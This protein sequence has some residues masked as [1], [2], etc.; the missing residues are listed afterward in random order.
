MRAL[1][2]LTVLGASACGGSPPPPAAAP[3]LKDLSVDEGLPEEDQ[4]YVAEMTAKLA[5]LA[6][7]LR[8]PVGLH[9]MPSRA[10]LD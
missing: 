4:V 6:R 2:L 8:Q 3:R 7:T 1:V 5:T 9:F 10:A